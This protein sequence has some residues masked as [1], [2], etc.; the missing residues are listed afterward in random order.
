MERKLIAIDLD[1][2]TLNAAAEIAP[3]TKAVLKE[4][5][6]A[7]HIVSIVTGRPNRISANIYDELGL[8]SPSSS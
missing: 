4:A 2:T 1:G 5:R 3:R 8:S 6:A 7:G